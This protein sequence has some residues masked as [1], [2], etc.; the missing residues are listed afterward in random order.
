MSIFP[1]KKMV[2]L[3]PISPTEVRSENSQLHQPMHAAFTDY[4]SQAQ[5]I[6]KVIGDIGKHR[7]ES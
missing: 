2:Y 1:D 3:V 7:Q 4:K 6:E 5:T